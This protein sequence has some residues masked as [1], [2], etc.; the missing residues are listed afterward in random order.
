MELRLERGGNAHRIHRGLTV[1]AIVSL[2]LIFLLL[3]AA[4][5][6]L[7]GIRLV[8]RWLITEDP[9]EAACCIVVLGGHPPVRAMEAA[10]IYHQGWAPEIWMTQFPEL[11]EEATLRSFG[12]ETTPEFVITSRV[13]EKLDVPKN[14]IIL[15]D[16]SSIDTREELQ[17]VHRALSERHPSGPVILVTSRYHSRRVRVIWKN[18]A[19]SS[20]RAVIR[21]AANDS[22]PRDKWFLNTT[23]LSM[24]AHEFFGILNL[25]VGHPVRRR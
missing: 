19:G 25:W 20:R 18:V 11:A 13:L 14:A 16:E 1:V 4:G 15:L 12:I 2:T 7:V 6:L 17:N 21:T 24:V 23:D 9:L 10:A 8:G 22:F 3:F 5:V